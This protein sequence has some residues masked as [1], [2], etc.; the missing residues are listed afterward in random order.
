MGL[1]ERFKAKVKK[2]M[3]K[4]LADKPESAGDKPDWKN[5]KK[6]KKGLVEKGY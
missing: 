2:P 3:G 5:M 1:A 4:M 6:K